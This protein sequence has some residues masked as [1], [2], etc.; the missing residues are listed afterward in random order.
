MRE[1]S[2]TYMIARKREAPSRMRLQNIRRHI[3][4]KAVL[5]RFAIK[6]FLNLVAILG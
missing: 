6:L 1:C 3:C 5:P 2:F 4:V